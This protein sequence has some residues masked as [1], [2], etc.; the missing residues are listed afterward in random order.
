MVAGLTLLTL[1]LWERRARWMAPLAWWPG[2][3]VAIL[4]VTPWLVAVQ[5]ATNGAFLR[6][7]IFGD[8]APKLAS[9]HEG[10][11]GLPGFHLA[12]LA[13]TFFQPPLALARA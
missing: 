12:L 1:A 6:D 5:V 3:I 4:I 13:L 11:S 8:L 10:H 2:P 7:A 9:G